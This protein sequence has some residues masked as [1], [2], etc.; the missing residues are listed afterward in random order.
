[1]WYL[2]FNKN[3]EIAN[4]AEHITYLFGQNSYK[5]IKNQEDFRKPC[6]GGSKW[7]AWRQILLSV[8]TKK[9]DFAAI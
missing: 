2:P 9:V 6:L 1:M 8:T 5:V 7:M 4:Y 3:N